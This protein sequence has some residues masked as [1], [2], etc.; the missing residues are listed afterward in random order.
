[1]VEKCANPT[2]TAIFQRLRDGRLFVME[3]P[4]HSPVTDKKPVRPLQ[5]FWLCKSC[6]LT[7]TLMIDKQTGITVVPLPPKIITTRTAS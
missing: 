6:C 3:A 5:Y 4:A 7:M 2:C 1:M